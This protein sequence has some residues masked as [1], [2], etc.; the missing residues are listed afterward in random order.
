VTKSKSDKNKYYLLQIVSF[1]VDLVGTLLVK[2][3]LQ[4]VLPPERDESTQFREAEYASRLV[5]P[6]R[7]ESEFESV[8]YRVTNRDSKYSR[9]E[10]V[11]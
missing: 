6:N 10:S 5:G 11:Y 2:F 8:K 3:I 7:I 4:V 1:D 9:E